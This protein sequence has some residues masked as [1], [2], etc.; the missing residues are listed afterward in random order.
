[1]LA[2]DADPIPGD[3][4]TVTAVNGQSDDVGQTLAGNYGTLTLNANGSYS[5][6]AND[7]SFMPP[8]LS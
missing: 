2:N 7:E 5:Y 8:I 6:V 4:L 1:M 3:T